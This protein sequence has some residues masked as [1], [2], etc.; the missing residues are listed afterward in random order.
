VACT[1]SPKALATGGEWWYQIM[2]KVPSETKSGPVAVSKRDDQSI[3]AT[4]ARAV[5]LTEEA[6]AQVARIAIEEIHSGLEMGMH[7]EAAERDM[8]GALRQL[9]LAERE[10][11]AKA[12]ARARIEERPEGVAKLVPGPGSEAVRSGT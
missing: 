2:E 11:R 7:V 9:I 3:I 5:E 6:L 12:G 10:L 1:T 4:M 8:R